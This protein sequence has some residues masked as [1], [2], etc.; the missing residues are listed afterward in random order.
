[1]LKQSPYMYQLTHGSQ[2]IY[3]LQ[4][5]RNEHQIAPIPVFNS[6]LY[7]LTQLA[8]ILVPNVRLY[9]F[10][11]KIRDDCKCILK[12]LTAS[13]SMTQ[14]SLTLAISA[15]VPLIQALLAPALPIPVLSSEATPI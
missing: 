15:Q 9:Y 8:P 3:D 13:A 5:R 12:R 1:M 10:N 14:T 6:M 4:C 7:L 11:S 2:Y